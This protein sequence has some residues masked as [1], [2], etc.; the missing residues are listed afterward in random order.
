MACLLIHGS[1]D[2]QELCLE[3]STQGASAAGPDLCV[4]IAP[5]SLSVRLQQVQRLRG[6]GTGRGWW[7]VV[8]GGDE[9]I[10]HVGRNVNSL[11]AMG[12]L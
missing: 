12:E 4:Q 5:S 9:R 7:G 3:N 11:C 10:L 1:S 8:G 2:C 6:L